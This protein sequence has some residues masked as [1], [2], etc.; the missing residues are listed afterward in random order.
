MHAL[1]KP[2]AI[3]EEVAIFKNKARRVCDG[4]K[5]MLAASRLKQNCVLLFK[6]GLHLT[7]WLLIC[8][9]ELLNSEQFV[10]ELLH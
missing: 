10:L 8:F 7:T 5:N 6:T 4:E 1:H 2:S 9:E 3:P